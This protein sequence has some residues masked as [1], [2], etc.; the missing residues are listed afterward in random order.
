MY[1]SGEVKWIPTEENSADIFTK[2][3]NGPAFEKHATTYVGIDQ[4]MKQ[5]E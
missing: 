2:N 4:Y 3:L 5:N 1:L